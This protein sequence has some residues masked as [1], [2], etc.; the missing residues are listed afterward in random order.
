[1]RNFIAI[2]LMLCSMAGFL[3]GVVGLVKPSLCKGK[4]KNGEI[5]SR[6]EILAGICAMFFLF[7]ISI[8]VIPTQEEHKDVIKEEPQVTAQHPKLRLNIPL[9]TWIL[10]MNKNLK[11]ANLSEL[12][13]ST[14]PDTCAVL[15]SSK[16][17]TANGV[18]LVTHDQ[19]S[20]DSIGLV[21]ANDGTVENVTGVMLNVLALME[22]VSAD[23]PKK[24]LGQQATL[25]MTTTFR[26]GYF[27]KKLGD[28]NYMGLKMATG[29][30]LFSVDK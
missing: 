17:M 16:Y 8:A 14:E 27:S 24:E 18:Y 20:I 5:P 12:M 28:V 7:A 22:T 26:K 25:M 9:A 23:I 10:D 19:N 13:K 29:S 21:V 11:E 4:W 6:K 15:C 1:M 3:V 2:A 30:W